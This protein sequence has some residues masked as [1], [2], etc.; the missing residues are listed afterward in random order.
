[1]KPNIEESQI[2]DI[3]LFTEIGDILLVWSLKN[4]N[5]GVYLRLKRSWICI[6]FQPTSKIVGKRYK[7]TQDEGAPWSSGSQYFLVKNSHGNNVKID[8]DYDKD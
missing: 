2:K 4:E 5:Q 8:T 7:L 3:D 1:M 6:Q